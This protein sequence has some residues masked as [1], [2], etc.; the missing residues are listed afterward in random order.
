[1]SIQIVEERLD[2]LLKA[3]GIPNGASYPDIVC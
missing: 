2:T 3:I 1:M